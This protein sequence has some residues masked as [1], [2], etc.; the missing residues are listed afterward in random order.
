MLR[1]RAS[2]ATLEY[3]LSYRLASRREQ[4]QWLLFYS[5]VLLVPDRR[6]GGT[7][8]AVR[9]SRRAESN[10]LLALYKGAWSP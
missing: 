8:R 9:W 5:R 3:R 10:R 6:V 2:A 7:T 4:P 1:I